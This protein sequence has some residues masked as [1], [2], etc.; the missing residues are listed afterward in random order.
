MNGF[1]TTKDP[2]TGV[3]IIGMNNELGDNMNFK[4]M[5][6]N[7]DPGN[8][9]NWIYQTLLAAE[10]AG[11]KVLIL[12]HIPHGCG[13]ANSLWA[14]HYRVLVNRFQNIIIA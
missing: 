14:R 2:K 5:Q 10:K 7:T 3:R 1:Y 11:E 8:M 6:N 9:I 4:L 12:G 13:F